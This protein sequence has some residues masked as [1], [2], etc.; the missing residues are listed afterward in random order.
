[1]SHSA[2][3]VRELR[4]FPTRRS[5]DL[6]RQTIELQAIGNES[7]AA[8]EDLYYDARY[9]IWEM[10]KNQTVT[11]AGHLHSDRKST[12]QNSS[13]VKISYAVFCLKKKKI[14]ICGGAARARPMSLQ[15]PADA[16]LPER[17]RSRGA[18]IVLS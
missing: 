12:R 1:M 8:T 5:S 4:S 18:S 11:P 15:R 10:V 14:G 6:D 2:A 17:R 13:H 3:S 7:L 16:L 9:V